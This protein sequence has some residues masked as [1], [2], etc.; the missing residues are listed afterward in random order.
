MRVQENIDKTTQI[1]FFSPH[2]YI[3]NYSKNC[4][5]F[6][7]ILFCWKALIPIL[8]SLT[9]KQ[10]KFPFFT[11]IWDGAK[12]KHSPTQPDATTPSVCQKPKNELQP[13]NEMQVKK[14]PT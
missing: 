12:K 6:I 9:Q 8:Y 4:N 5:E 11:R 14:Y 2:W 13:W 1:I 3:F 7:K 10:Y